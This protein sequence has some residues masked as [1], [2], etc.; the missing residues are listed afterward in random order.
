M[1]AFLLAGGFGTRLR[2]LTETTP[3]CLVPIAGK[4]LLQ[5]WLEDVFALGCEQMLINTHYLHRQVEDFVAQSPYRNRIV[6]A[7][8]PQLLGTLG[9]IRHN[10][11]FLQQSDCIIAHADNFCRTDWQDFWQCHLTRPEGCVGTMMLFTTQTPHSCGMVE[12]DAAKVLQSYVEKPQGPYTGSL[13]NGAVF[14]FSPDAIAD[15]CQLPEVC[16]DLCRDYLPQQL[17][18]MMTYHNQQLLIDI[19]TPET[20]QKANDIAATWPTDA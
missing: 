15:M 2:P 9:S 7:H 14:A 20:Y 3:K 13:A 1:R 11:A 17:G 12:T 18:K 6:L 19:G 16:D 5:W 10:Q 8:E 4:P